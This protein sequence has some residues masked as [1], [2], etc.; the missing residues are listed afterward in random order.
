VRRALTGSDVAIPRLGETIVGTVTVGSIDTVTTARTHADLVITPAVAGIGLLDW[1]ALMQVR[2]IGR[3]AA[4][5]ALDDEPELLARL[6]SPP[7]PRYDGAI[8]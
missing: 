8:G 1:K 7:R 6:G 5:R 2:E 3:A 4:R